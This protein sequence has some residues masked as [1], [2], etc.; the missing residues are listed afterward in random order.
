V[1]STSLLP[2]PL[3]VLALTA[4]RARQRWAWWTLLAANTIAF[5]AP[6]TYDITT[7]AIGPFEMLEWAALASVLLALTTT[8]PLFAS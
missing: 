5:L 7:G 4:F 8:W 6:I 1:H 3:S 2:F